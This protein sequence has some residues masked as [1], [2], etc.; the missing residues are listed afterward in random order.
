MALIFSV[1]GTEDDPDYDRV[2]QLPAAIPEAAVYIRGVLADY[3]RLGRPLWP[4]V[5]STLYAAFLANETG[6]ARI[7]ILTWDSSLHGWGLLL[8]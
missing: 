3:A 7:A 1:I 8:R 6:T 4:F 2:V 5:P